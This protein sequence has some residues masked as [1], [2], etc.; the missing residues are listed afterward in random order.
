MCIKQIFL[1]GAFINYLL[2]INIDCNK[3]FLIYLMFIRL[4]YMMLN[5]VY[6]ITLSIEVCGAISRPMSSN[7][8]QIK[9]RVVIE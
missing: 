7:K 1:F 8:E 6:L 3:N 2:N 9:A 5:N 4:I